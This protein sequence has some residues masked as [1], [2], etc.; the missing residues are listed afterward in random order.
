MEGR[1]SPKLATLLPLAGALA[2]GL[3]R[4]ADSGSQTVR[5]HIQCHFRSSLFDVEIIAV[6]FRFYDCTLETGQKTNFS[7]VA[8]VQFFSFPFGFAP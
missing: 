8:G 1:N 4:P 5:R 3:E 2:V 7:I 6:P